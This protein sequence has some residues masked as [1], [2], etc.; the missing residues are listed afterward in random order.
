MAASIG[1][2][3][4]TE[5]IKR[6]GDICH[7]CGIAVDP[8]AETYAPLARTFDHVIPLISGG[9]HSM[10]NVKV[11]HR[12]CNVRKDCQTRRQEEG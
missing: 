1:T 3:D 10:D 4:L 9:A 7:I 8:N 11:A 5:I 6:D 2:V 12:L